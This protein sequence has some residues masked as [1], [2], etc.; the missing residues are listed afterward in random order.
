MGMRVRE[1]RGETKL[2][3]VRKQLRN[4]ARLADACRRMGV[5]EDS[6]RSWEAHPGAD[7]RRH[8]R[9]MEEKPAR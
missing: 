9:S 7:E 8:S 3:E 1:S 6:Y 2:A 4:G 5:R